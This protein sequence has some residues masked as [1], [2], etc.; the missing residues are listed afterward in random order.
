LFVSPMVASCPFITTI[1]FG[2]FSFSGNKR[3]SDRCGW[4]AGN[5]A[6]YWGVTI[7]TLP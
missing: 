5:S 3:S 7:V 2:L 4:E 1:S 6:L